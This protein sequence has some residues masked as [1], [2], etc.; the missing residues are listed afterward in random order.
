MKYVLGVIWLCILGCSGG[1]RLPDMRETY[2]T[3]SRQ[4][5][6]TYVAQQMLLGSYPG[7]TMYEL[8][9]A[10]NTQ[11][12]ESS[13]LYVTITKQFY[14]IYADLL[15]M[16]DYLQEGNTL[17]I[18]SS[19]FDST[20]LDYF[21][22]KYQPGNNWGIG[23]PYTM[24]DAGVRLSG[25]TDSVSP[26]FTYFF[27]PFRNHFISFP[28]S[29]SI[30]GYNDLGQPNFI[31]VPV[32]EGQMYL[33]AEPRVF[34]NY[35]LLTADNYRYFNG[36]FEHIHNGQETVYWDNYYKERIHSQEKRPNTSYFSELMKHPSL[37]AATLLF[38]ALMLLYVL[39]ESRR[40]HPVIPVIKPHMN[41]SLAFSET[42]ARLYLQHRNHK[43]IA[44]KMI[45]YFNEYLRSRYSLQSFNLEEQSEWISKKS[46]VKL[47][48]VHALAYCIKQVHDYDQIDDELLAELND[49]IFK[50]YK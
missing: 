20:F 22:I 35:F 6:G 36:I 48:D 5:F 15:D 38:L 49:H 33:H 11:Y 45:T 12:F 24:L 42:I 28:D 27:Y 13:S 44:L 26:V 43:D 16:K 14:P 30:W 17:F 8:D 39:L 32:G 40:K 9:K 7:A 47:E 34:S 3:K 50:F 31:S 18:V 19:N 29:S 1:K 37:K 23:D 21:D 10:F 2:N 41:S 4:P 25:L 46:G